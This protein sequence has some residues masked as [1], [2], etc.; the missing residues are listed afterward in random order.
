M[1]GK[2]ATDKIVPSIETIIGHV[3]DTANSLEETELRKMISYILKAERIFVMGAGRSGLVARAFAMRLMHLGFTVYVVGETTTPAVREK[4]VVIAISGSGETISIVNLGKIAKELGSKLVVITSSK[5]SSLAKLSDV[6]VTV[7][8]RGQTTIED[9]LER[10]MRG[11]YRSIAPLGTLF[12]I[13]S[14]IVLDAVIAQMMSI[15]GATE[16]EL[17]ERHA[18]LE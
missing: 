2:A 18:V 4:D 11:E 16:V 10:H 6:T 1:K 5:K 17:K 8:G 14:L 7:K 12:E 3:K 13:T 15:L 9:Y